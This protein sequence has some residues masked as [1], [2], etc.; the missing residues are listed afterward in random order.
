MRA[1][2]KNLWLL[3]LIVLWSGCSSQGP[4]SKRDNFAYL[5]GAGGAQMPLKARVHH[6]SP[7]LS[8]VYYSLN[9]ADLLYKS[10]GTGGPFRAQVRISYE[11]YDAYG[12]K[13]LLDSAGAFIDD[14]SMNPSEEKE[15][16]GSMDL[17]RNERR[18]FVLKIMAHDLNR[19]LQS[20]V[21]LRVD[22]DGPSKGQ[23]FMPVDTGTTLPL[24]GD[25]FKGGTMR[26][27][28]GVC[29][30]RTLTVHRFP[31]RTELPAPVFSTGTG[32]AKPGTGNADSTFTVNVDDDG[33]FALDIRDPGAYR[34][35][36]DTSAVPWYSVYSV[37]EA[38]PII[39]S[40][41]DLLKPLRYITSNQEYDRIAGSDDVRQAVERFW[42]DAAGDRERG[43]EAIRIYYG[44]VENANRHFTAEAEGWRTD[45]GLVH[46]IFGI[47]TSI[48][49]SDR[50]ETWTYG[51]ENNLMS[52]SFTFTRRPGALNENDMVLERDPLL[53][54]AWYR[55]VE[56]WR[57]G[58]VYQN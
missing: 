6:L 14:A 58:R 25:H 17:H 43:R 12:S 20:S 9:T 2:Y 19:D 40:D 15:L 38:Y 30:G 56:S 34:I 16:I 29:T 11:T 1:P 3:P 42:I 31:A 26:V 46:I 55:N 21:L 8:R 5:Y 7:D 28:C 45:R 52:L 48:Y 13:T 51:E 44:R 22:K 57:N 50:S 18:S 37:S 10:D 35:H 33:L 27:R 41:D 36:G 4:I 23:Y 49:K 54:G 53:K 32:A 39:V 24:F 47:P